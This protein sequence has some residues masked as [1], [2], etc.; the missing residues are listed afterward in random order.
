MSLMNNENLIKLCS[1]MHD[2]GYKFVCF[3]EREV[4][5][6]TDVSQSL[7]LSETPENAF[8][9]YRIEHLCTGLQ[10]VNCKSDHITFVMDIV[11]DNIIDFYDPQLRNFVYKDDDTDQ[12]FDPIPKYFWRGVASKLNVS[13]VSMGL[14][15][16]DCLLAKHTVS[17]W[18][19]IALNTIGVVS[20]Y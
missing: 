12:N 14:P 11:N 4:T 20:V 13:G 6:Y 15:P 18:N 1:Q 2:K 3:D 10:Y 8:I 17:I 5:V 7:C 16:A 9:F 19:C